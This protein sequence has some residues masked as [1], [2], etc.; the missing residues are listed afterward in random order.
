M[1]NYHLTF[2]FT[3]QFNTP[4]LRLTS[5]R[6][7]RWTIHDINVTIIIIITIIIILVIISTISIVT[8][9]TCFYYVVDISLFTY[10]HIYCTQT[11]TCVYS[12]RTLVIFVFITELQITYI[13]IFLILIYFRHVARLRQLGAAK[14]LKGVIVTG[15]H[16]QL[17]IA[18]TGGATVLRV[19]IQNN[20]VGGASR[21][22]FYL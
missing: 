9:F 16:T 12:G 7:I 4:C 15:Q 21:K 5:C 1:L 22:I 10:I 18:I 17:T 8:I 2:Q 6:P 14:I 19:E 11:E 3:T 13:T 20:A